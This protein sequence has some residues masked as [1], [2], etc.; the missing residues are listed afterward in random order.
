MAVTSQ[1][2]NTSIKF[3]A[4]K[5]DVYLADV[6]YDQLEAEALP[7]LRESH[8]DNLS[9]MGINV[10]QAETWDCDDFAKSLWGE[11]AQRNALRRS[12]DKLP[13]AFGMV[14]YVDPKHGPHAVCWAFTADEQLLFIEPQPNAP[15][16]VWTPSGKEL[17]SAWLFI[18]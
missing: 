17:D 11:V 13:L 7:K 9:R 4:P 12:S 8:I 10:Y 5:A 15:R 6:E 16:P 3:F 18:S 2:L 1:L 14:W